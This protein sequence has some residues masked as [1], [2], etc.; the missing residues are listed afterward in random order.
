MKI[1][2]EIGGNSRSCR[3]NPALAEQIDRICQNQPE[4]SL[5]EIRSMLISKGICSSSNVPTISLIHKCIRL[6]I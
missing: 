2:F 5:H 3:T 1:Y 4:I 6:L